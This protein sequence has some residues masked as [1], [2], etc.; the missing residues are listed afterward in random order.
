M[1]PASVPEGYVILLLSSSKHVISVSGWRSALR[2]SHTYSPQTLDA[3]RVLGLRIAEGR[4]RWTQAELC[5]RAGVSKATLR[6]AERGEPTVAVGVMFELATLVGVEL[7]G[8]PPRD[9]RDLAARESDRLALLPAHVYPR[10]VSVD[11]NF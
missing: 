8:L 1:D 5:E 3:A 11:D 7:Y 4:R 6:N 2:R 9:L 10:Q